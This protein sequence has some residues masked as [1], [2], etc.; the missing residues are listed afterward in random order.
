M[1]NRWRCGALAAILAVA[2]PALAHGQGDGKKP[3]VPAPAAQPPR[4]P[5]RPVTANPGI[6]LA[7]IGVID[8]QAVLR[9]STAAQAL[10]AHFKAQ[11]DDFQA[12]IE[13]QQKDLKVGDEELE[14]QRSSLSPE[15]FAERRRKLQERV[16]QV[17]TEFRARRR[18][19]EEI[20]NAAMA[21]LQQNLN[22]VVEDVAKRSGVNL[23][24]RKEAVLA[25][26]TALDLTQPTL[27]EF[28]RRVPSIKVSFPQRP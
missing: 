11:Q 18:Q 4:T 8:I 9:Q 6:P 2:V 7:S 25:N 10:Q 28:N 22:A 5:D 1:S 12:A 26:L 15:A 16:N 24:L 3:A 19:M 27:E 17:N 21:E 13:K 23:V 20:F 14:R